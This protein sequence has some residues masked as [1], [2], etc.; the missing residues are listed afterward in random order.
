M[1]KLYWAYGSNLNVAHMRQRCPSAAPLEALNLPDAILRFRHVADV[2][3][4]TGATCPGGLW[5]ITPDCEAALDG[6]E[7]VR[8][9]LYRKVYI[10]L[11]YHGAVR[12]A[13]LYQMN[14]VGIMPPSETYLETIVQGYEDFGLDVAR[15]ER[16]VAHSWARKNK[17]K[18]VRRRYGARGEA[19]LA[20]SVYLLDSKTIKP[21]K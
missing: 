21:D 11:R 2:A 3:Y 17:T 19:K 4:L 10:T 5:E 1:T 6:Y 20:E 8:Y 16:A 14:M 7:G 18:A 15:L 13:L 12:K 9:G